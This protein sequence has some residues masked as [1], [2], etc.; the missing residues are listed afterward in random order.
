MA[1][2]DRK[3]D[4][5]RG[6]LMDGFTKP[7]PLFSSP[8]IY[9]PYKRPRRIL[10]AAP[11]ASCHSLVAH[12]RAKPRAP[13]RSGPTQRTIFPEGNCSFYSPYYTHLEKGMF[14]IKS[15]SWERDTFRR[16]RDGLL[17][18]KS[19]WV[20]YHSHGALSTERTVPLH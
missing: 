18:T 4:L 11:K 8:T 1:D 15:C 16:H 19:P 9:G 13:T 17:T 6:F 20:L 3:A 7:S 2:G 10:L 5:P 14:S 12:A